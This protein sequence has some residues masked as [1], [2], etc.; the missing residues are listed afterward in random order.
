MKYMPID[1]HE[2]EFNKRHGIEFGYSF[3]DGHPESGLEFKVY[4]KNGKVHSRVKMNEKQI[5]GFYEHLHECIF[6]K[7]TEK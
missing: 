3:E 7:E 1:K 2:A 5:R 6:G 4:D